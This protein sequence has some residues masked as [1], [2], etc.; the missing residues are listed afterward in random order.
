MNLDEWVCGECMCS[1]VKS[2]RWPLGVKSKQILD[3]NASPPSDGDGDGDGDA[4]GTGEV[5]E[6]RL[7]VSCI[8]QCIQF[9]LL[10]L[11]PSWI[12]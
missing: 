2:K 5:L 10:F 4:D 8:C 9:L 7:V 3:I 11:S 1:G 12:L 6:L